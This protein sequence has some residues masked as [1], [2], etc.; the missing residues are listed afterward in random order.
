MKI[1]ILLSTENY[2]ST[3]KLALNDAGNNFAHRHGSRVL[4]P[5]RDVLVVRRRCLHHLRNHLSLPDVRRIAKHQLPVLGQLD[6]LLLARL[7]ARVGRRLWDGWKVKGV[8]LG[9]G[10]VEGFLL[11][12]GHREERIGEDGGGGSAGRDC[13]LGGFD[14]DGGGGGWEETVATGSSDRG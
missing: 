3:L 5:C 13:P 12:H 1:T 7:L 4:T 11:D 2:S 10:V 9:W 6:E 14:D 8:F